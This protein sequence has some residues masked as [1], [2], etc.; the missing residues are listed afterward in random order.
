MNITGIMYAPSV[1]ISITN[2]ANVGACMP[3][4]AYGATI[5]GSGKFNLTCST[6]S[7]GSTGR[8]QLV[9]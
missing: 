5:S 4:I 8:P 7:G 3:L 6:G 2:N 1:Q 9:E